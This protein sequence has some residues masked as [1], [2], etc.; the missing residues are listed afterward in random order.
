MRIPA[1]VS[2]D[3][4]P[5]SDDPA[6]CRALW[7]VGLLFLLLGLIGLRCLL[8]L[9]LLQRLLLTLLWLRWGRLLLGLLLA[10]ILLFQLVVARAT[11]QSDSCGAD[12]GARGRGEQG[13]SREAIAP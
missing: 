6:T 11:D 9:R 5:G 7:I 12:A 1:V 4:Q 3:G 8:A 13:A 10:L 2:F